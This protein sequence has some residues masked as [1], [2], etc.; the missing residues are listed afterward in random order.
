MLTTCQAGIKHA[1]DENIGI[2]TDG[3]LN[4]LSFIPA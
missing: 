2:A 4:H 1:V 3:R